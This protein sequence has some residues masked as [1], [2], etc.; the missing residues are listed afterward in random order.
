MSIERVTEKPYTNNYRYITC[1]GKRQQG[2][3]K[4]VQFFEAYITKNEYRVV[5]YNGEIT[6]DYYLIRTPHNGHI[7]AELRGAANMLCM[8]DLSKTE[9]KTP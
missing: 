2:Q 7:T 9:L 5:S 1:F 6:T 8:L 3:L 4:V